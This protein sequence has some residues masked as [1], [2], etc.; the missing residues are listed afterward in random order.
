MDLKEIVWESV[1]WIDLAW[2][3]GR[4]WALGTCVNGNEPLGS[5]KAGIFLT[6]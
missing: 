3:W 1:D 2:N 6:I 5:I 4:W